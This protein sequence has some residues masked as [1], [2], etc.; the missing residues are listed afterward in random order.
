M[1]MKKIQY[2]IITLVVLLLTGC[3]STEDEVTQQYLLPYPTAIVALDRSRDDLPTIRLKSI[4]VPSYLQKQNMVLVN[5]DGQVYLAANHLWAETI[6]RQLEQKTLR[7]LSERLPKV[8]WLAPSLYQI[9][10]AYLT[11]TVESFYASTEGNVTVSGYWL[12]WG[13]D[14]TL[15]TQGR[16]N[17]H[18][19]LEQ[20]GYLEMTKTLSDTWFDRVVEQIIA[21]LYPK[22]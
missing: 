7:Y 3:S 2:Y 17:Q 16:F 1:T 8:D 6:E 21:S 4:S 20:D 18:N 15:M 10:S 22:T 12:L 5:N 13:K 19:K 9:Q 14:N 11:I